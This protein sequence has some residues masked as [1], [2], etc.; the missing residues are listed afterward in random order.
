MKES[1]KKT[2]WKARAPTTIL[3]DQ[4]TKVNGK[5]ANITE[6][7]FTSFQMEQ[8]TKENG[9]TTSY[10]VLDTILMPQGENGMVSLEEEYLKVKGKLS[11]SKREAYSSKNN[12]YKKRWQQPS[13]IYWILWLKV[14]KKHLKTT[15]RHFLHSMI[16]LKSSS[17]S[18][19]QNLMRGLLKN[20]QNTSIS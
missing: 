7:V 20:G 17:K 5:I 10:M 18:L 13:K 6:R 15:L 14:I 19:M 16:M 3:T 1:G 11:L 12:K 4:C 8:Y 2:K 9:K